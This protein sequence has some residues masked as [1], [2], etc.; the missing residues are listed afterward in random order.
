MIFAF[1]LVHFGLAVG[2]RL[3]IYLHLYPLP[4]PEQAALLKQSA[5][6]IL[7]DLGLATLSAIA[8]TMLFFLRKQAFNLLVAAFVLS[9][10]GT[11]WQMLSGSPMAL[12]MSQNKP[13]LVFG[14]LS[15]IIA[16]GISFAFC[17]YAWRLR[18]R[19]VLQ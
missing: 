18:Q 7:F 8:G 11:S 10:G 5:V 19:G 4:E 17:F 1:Y 3:L 16:W 15:I 6:S 9:I 2:T 13:I 12:V 14:W